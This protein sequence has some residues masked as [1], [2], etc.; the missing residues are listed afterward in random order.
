MNQ[1]SE[2]IVIKAE[3]YDRIDGKNA[4]S[5]DTKRLTLGK[6]SKPENEAMKIAA[7]IWKENEDGELVIDTELPVHQVMD[8]A[9]FL[10]KTISYFMDAYRY[11]LLYNTENPV[12]ERVGVQGDAMHIEVCTENPE[13]NKDIQDFSQSLSDLGELTGERL[14][15]LSRII[16]EMGY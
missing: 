8:A 9:I 1:N 12:I 11:P 13:I 2:N 6:P 5:S 10:I 15:I 14:R 4:Y 7:F 3:N 16:R